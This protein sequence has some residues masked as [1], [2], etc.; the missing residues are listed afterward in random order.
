[1]RRVFM[2]LGVF[3]GLFLISSVSLA[4]PNVPVAHPDTVAATVNGAPIMESELDA[5]IAAKLGEAETTPPPEILSQA[6]KEI[7]DT[8]ILMK[9]LDE[10]TKKLN[11]EVSDKEI[12]LEISKILAEQGLSKEDFTALLAAYGKSFEDMRKEIHRRLGYEKLSEVEFA[13]KINITASDA[14]NYYK[15]NI[16]EF[17]RPERIRVSHILIGIS[18]TDPN[19]DPNQAKDAAKSKAV[20]ILEQL[21]KGA[22]FAALARENSICPSRENSGDLQQFLTRDSMI[23]AAFRD[24]A[25]ALQQTGQLSDIVETEFG[26]HIIKLNERQPGGASSFDEVREQIMENLKTE[27]QR[28]LSLELIDRL[29]VEATITYADKYKPAVSLPAPSDTNDKK[30]NPEKEVENE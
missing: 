13:G 16:T 7:L 24:A 4:E 26:Y 12:D 19:S 22:D 23:P 28:K 2:I 1:M 30:I 15:Q 10:R 21:K 6:K 8:L 9:L 29:R 3:T 5:E 14:E 11:L 17:E 25:F 20:T 27:E 18:S